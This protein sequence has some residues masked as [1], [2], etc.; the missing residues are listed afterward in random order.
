MP[1]TIRGDGLNLVHKALESLVQNP[2]LLDRARMRFSRSPPVYASPES[3]TPTELG[4]S[5]ADRRDLRVRERLASEPDSQFR[6][7]IDEEKYKL[8]L[9]P[10]CTDKLPPG[11][12]LDSYARDVVKKRWIEQGI[13]N[14]SWKDECLGRWK[15]EESFNSSPRRECGKRLTGEQSALE[16]A[17]DINTTAYQSVKDNWSARG[18]WNK[19]WGLLPGMTWKHEHPLDED[20]LDDRA[21]SEPRIFGDVRVADFMYIRSPDYTRPEQGCTTPFGW[22]PSPEQS[23]CN[24][25]PLASASSHCQLRA[26]KREE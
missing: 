9:Y 21:H 14:D 26:F 3:V 22:Q 20:D 1:E 10:D 19:K 13:W 2:E 25:S 11:R 15:H 23:I 17:T 8:E 6:Y 12:G 24:L 18:L 7:E 16:I 5:T 4:N